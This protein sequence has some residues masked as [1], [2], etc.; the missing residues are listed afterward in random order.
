[1]MPTALN[2]E[3]FPALAPF[4][5]KRAPM[6][7]DRPIRAATLVASGATSAT[8]G[9]APGPT[10][11]TTKATAKSGQG[12]TRASPRARR[13]A[14]AAA[15]A[16]VPLASVAAKSSVTPSSVRKSDEGKA[17]A[18]P[19]ARTP[20]RARPSRKASARAATP[21]LTR[22]EKLSAMATSSARSEA[23]AGLTGGSL[24]LESH[25]FS[26]QNA[27]TSLLACRGF[28]QF[29]QKPRFGT[30]RALQALA[31][32]LHL[33]WRCGRSRRRWRGRRGA[34]QARW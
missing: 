26:P 15:R 34:P 5:T 27:H 8:L 29:Q 25:C 31:D 3:R 33:A 20:G 14:R 32:V 13:T 23:T 4:A 6:K 9:T 7:G 24:G 16:S 19:S 11:D 2:G 1:M 17:A 10:A 18:T 28:L 30:S 22:A 12:T 21:T